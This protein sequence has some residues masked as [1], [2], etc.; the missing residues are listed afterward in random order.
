MELYKLLF[1]NEFIESYLTRVGQDCPGLFHYKRP[2]SYGFNGFKGVFKN[3]NFFV[4]QA[5]GV[6]EEPRGEPQCI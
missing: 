4:S 2:E 1:L 3:N 6:P 5:A